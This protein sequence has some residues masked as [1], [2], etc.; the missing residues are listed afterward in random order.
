MRLTRTLG[1]GWLVAATF[2]QAAQ[3]DETVTSIARPTPISAFGGV[4]AWSAYDAATERYVLMA[5]TARAAP[6]PLPIRPRRV[7][8][9]IDLG[10]GPARGVVAA[11]ARCRTEPG[12][13][14]LGNALAVMPGWSTGR[15]C[16]LYRFHFGTGRETRIRGAST[17]GASE[18]LPSIWRDRV[19][20][21]RVYEKRRG[22]AGQRSY[23]YRRALG[24]RTSRRLPAGARSRYRVCVVPPRDCSRS[25]LIVEPGPTALDLFGRHLA[26]GWDSGSDSPTSSLYLDS[27]AADSVRR[28]TLQRVSSGS[29]QGQEVISPAFAGAQL[30]WGFVRFGESQGNELRRLDLATGA[31]EVAPV[32]WAGLE[33]LFTPVLATAVDGPDA[34]YLI[35]AAA[36]RYELRRSGPLDF[37]PVS[38][39]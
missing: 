1:L 35:P 2:A 24:G 5:S 31:T 13:A 27:I 36:E 7:P 12:R 37:R 23:L 25:R 26:F 19:G 32:P 14:G 30:H 9:D 33:N 16:D 6:T 10:P 4:L 3:A 20:F 38:T 8:F 22:A 17:R 39:R 21:A 18:F 28:R 34:F 29:L 15:G 11:Y